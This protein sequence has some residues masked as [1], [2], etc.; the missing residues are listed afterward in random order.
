MSQGG[1]MQQIGMLLN[2]IR[3]PTIRSG[4]GTYITFAPHGAGLLGAASKQ[5]TGHATAAWKYG[6]PG[7]LLA[8]TGNLTE[9]WVEELVV[10]NATTAAKEWCVALTS[11]TAITAA[12]QIEA[13]IPITQLGTADQIR[14]KLDPPVHF[15]AGTLIA[16]AVAGAVA[17]KKVNVWAVISRAK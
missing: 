1:L 2:S 8:A 15:N 11:A 13:E 6:T 14:I 16:A 4:G 9:A 10:S 12:N 7:A 17:A 5:I 3:P